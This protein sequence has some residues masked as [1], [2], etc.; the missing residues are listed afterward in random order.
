MSIITMLAPPS[1]K[2][3]GLNVARCT[4]MAVVHDMAE[5]LVG[6]ITPQ[7]N[8]A[9]QEKSRRE[10]TTMEFL[11]QKMLGNKENGMDQSGQDIMDL[12]SEYEESK[13]LESKF[14][15]DVDKLEL[16]LQMVE[17]E[18]GFEK[19]RDLG[20]FAYVANKIQLPEV[21]TW[22]LEI[23]MER[24]R[25]WGEQHSSLKGAQDIAQFIKTQKH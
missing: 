10:E 8:V 7:D 12:W 4:Q 17:Y 20:E 2:A 9:K 21:R 6:D 13:T 25:F 22:C 23:L 11:T 19:E 1:L 14:V 24:Q 15:H 5:S 16:M 18:R 3:R